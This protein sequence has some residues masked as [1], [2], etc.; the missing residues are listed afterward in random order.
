MPDGCSYL[1]GPWYLWQLPS[2]SW[3]LG[4]TTESQYREEKVGWKTIREGSAPSL[5][6][7]QQDMPTPLSWRKGSGKGQGHTTEALGALATHL[8]GKRSMRIQVG[9]LPFPV[10]HP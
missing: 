10:K 4:L 7:V 3:E 1:T 5:M 6:V 2:Q 9:S 8:W